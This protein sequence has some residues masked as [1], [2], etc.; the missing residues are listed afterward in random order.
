MI[1]KIKK[2]FK[3]SEIIKAASKSLPE[4]N[5]KPKTAVQIAN[6]K[7]Y[8]ERLRRHNERVKKDGEAYQQ[9]LNEHLSSYFNNY[10]DDEEANQ[11]AY[12]L[13]NKEWK[14][15]CQ[16]VNATQKHLQLKHDRFEIEVARIVSENKQFQ[17]KK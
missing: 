13:L 8:Q 12:D 17:K 5:D 11:F 16:K 6:E 14:S 10:S 2:F 9:R 4:A 3:P 15:Y 1:D 7:I